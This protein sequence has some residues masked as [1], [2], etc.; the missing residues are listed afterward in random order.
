M[1]MYP[2]APGLDAPL[3]GPTRTS[4]AAILSLV[5]G[6]LGLIACCVPIAGPVFGVIGLLFAVFAFLAIGRSEGQVGGRGLAVGGMVCSIIALVVGI[7][8]VVGMN[9]A[10]TM[11]GKYGQAV[12]IAQSDD[13]SRLT[14]VLTSSSTQRLTPEEIETFKVESFGSLGKFKRV[15]PGMLPLF[16]TFGKLGPLMGS[17]PPGYQGGGYGMLPMPGE[18]EKGNGIILVIVDQSEQAPQWQ[19]GKVVNVGVAPEGGPITWL[20]DPSGP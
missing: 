15:T 3:P 11:I 1:T 9:L 18:F 10:T 7:F 19:M 13:P 20:L 8:V 4:I 2:N 16:S 6:I 14:E 12:E 17:I 5:C